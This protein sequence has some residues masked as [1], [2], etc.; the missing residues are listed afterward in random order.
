MDANPTIPSLGTLLG[1]W[2]HPDDEAYLSAGLMALA[3]RHGSRVVVATA[4]AGELGSPDPTWPDERVAGLRRRELAASLSELGVTEHRFLGAPDG[5]CDT[6]APGRGEA[7]VRSLIEDVDPGTIVTFGPDGMT[8]HADHQAVSRWTTRAW[9]ASGR[10]CRLWYATRTIEHRIR[11][12]G[13][14]EGLGIRMGDA[15]RVGVPRSDLALELVIDGELGDRKQRA[16]RAHASQA[17]RLVTTLG[18]DRFRAWTGN[19]WFVDAARL[20]GGLG[21]ATVEATGLPVGVS[22]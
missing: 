17:E 7:W 10:P 11:W 5:G 12:R 2:A 14:D 9:E 3:R 13:V 22:R 19:E 16:I 21:R 20:V 1:V 6:L 15:P 8:G 18:E 4:T